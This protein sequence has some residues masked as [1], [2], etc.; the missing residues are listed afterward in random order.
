M[1]EIL[2]YV[3]LAIVV[4]LSI[5]IEIYKWLTNKKIGNFVSAFNYPV[6]GV[7]GFLI[8]RSKYDIF[9]T[10]NEV[11]ENQPDSV[12][13]G[14]SWLGPQLVIT[15]TD[16]DDLKTVLTSDNC[17]DK[18]YVYKFFNSNN[19]L[20][21]A[22]KEQWKHDRRQLNPTL[23]NKIVAKYLPI[24]N[25]KAKVCTEI[26]ANANGIVDFHRIFMK[27]LL[28]MNF[29]TVFG[30][31][32]NLQE[33]H[34]DILYDS[35]MDVMA[36]NQTRVGQ[37]WLA[38]NFVYR[39]TKSYEQQLKSYVNIL[40]FINDVAVTK[41]AELNELLQQN[42]GKEDFEI[43]NITSN[44]NFLEKCFLL[45]RKG[46]M[47]EETLN[48]HGMVEISLLFDRKK[49]ELIILF[50]FVGYSLHS[51]SRRCGHKQCNNA[52]FMLDAS[53]AS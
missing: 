47:T 45:L 30:C 50:Y 9:A 52:E 12:T 5:A 53:N 48:D 42:A 44:L 15:L 28:D 14:Y 22:P 38:W 24:F 10:V 17:L 16:P 43:E 40:R 31:D 33:P 19:S 26:I 39:L 34:G 32:R 51:N 35:M 49:F 8:G 41:S 13:A 23:N 29:A 25:A 3:V 36:H 21:S 27:C 7:G 18:P 20:L 1:F 4:L 37:P 11:F 46:K 2:L 6:I